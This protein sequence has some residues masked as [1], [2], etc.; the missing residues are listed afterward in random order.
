[1]VE[2]DLAAVVG[3]L[4]ICVRNA[5]RVSRVAACLRGFMVVVAEERRDAR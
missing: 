2:N 1:M 5:G 4:M 3:R